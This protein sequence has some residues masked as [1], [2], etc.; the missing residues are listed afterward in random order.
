M[1]NFKE[2]IVYDIE[3]RR[4]IMEKILFTMLNSPKVLELYE[5]AR[6]K[7]EDMKYIKQEEFVA[8][9][10]LALELR[11]SM[12]VEAKKNKKLEQYLYYKDG[13]LNSQNLLKFVNYEVSDMIELKLNDSHTRWTL[14]VNKILKEIDKN[15]GKTKTYKIKE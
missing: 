10:A 7:S 14:S 4:R 15:E 11:K 8:I 12:P 2:E 6:L 9:Y 5:L 1:E 13:S 3:K